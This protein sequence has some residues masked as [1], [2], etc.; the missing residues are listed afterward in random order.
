MTFDFHASSFG[1]R[2][3]RHGVVINWSLRY[4]SLSFHDS[5]FE[6][7]VS[8][9]FSRVELQCVVAP[10]RAAPWEG[11]MSHVVTLRIAPTASRVSKVEHHASKR[12]QANA[13]FKFFA[14]TYARPIRCTGRSPTRQNLSMIFVPWRFPADSRI[15]MMV[16]NNQGI[17]R[18]HRCVRI[19]IST[20]DRSLT[21][22]DTRTHR[23]SYNTHVRELLGSSR[24][25]YSRKTPQRKNNTDWFDVPHLRRCY[26]FDLHSV[27]SCA[28]NRHRDRWSK[29]ISDVT[30]SKRYTDGTFRSWRDGS[31]DFCKSHRLKAT[32]CAAAGARC[33]DITGTRHT[34]PSALAIAAATC[35]RR[36]TTK[37]DVRN[38][39]TS[40]HLRTT[41]LG[42]KVLLAILT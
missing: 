33:R 6:I 41:H 30:S 10:W 9:N 15:T 25:D 23:S 35:G 14:R 17:T 29:S 7:R 18:V 8:R 13:F 11:S 28:H 38:A 39:G 2:I 32:S 4:V 26:R 5:A 37:R 31:E 21:Q 20:V 22:F 24:R 40:E 27:M 42:H 34:Q 16:R 36:E 12:S 19:I 1:L 3:A